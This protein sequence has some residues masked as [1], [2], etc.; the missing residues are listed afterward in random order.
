MGGW[1]KADNSSYCG[2]PRYYMDCNATCGCTTGCGGGYGFCEPGATGPTAAAGPA[3]CD[4]YLTGCLQFRYGQ[5]NQDVACIGRIVCRVVAC[6]PA[7]GGRPQLHHRPTPTTTGRRSR[8]Q[9]AGRRRPRPRRRPVQSPAT[10][11]QVVAVAASA[12]GP[13]YA[14]VTAFGRLFAYGD[15][16]TTGDVVRLALAQPIVGMA[17]D[18]DRAAT[19]SWPP[20]AGSSP[21]AAP[22]LRVHGRP[23]AEPADRRHGRHPDRPR[24]TGWWPP[25]AASSPSATPS[26]TAPWAAAP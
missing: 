3:G 17:A 24:A 1:W 21:S 20:T 12:D 18:P 22:V 25:T 15:A 11:C 7:L 6:V 26:S 8:T 19:G 13:G 4:S 16:P 10:N 23:P 9:P 14:I 5:C 2:G